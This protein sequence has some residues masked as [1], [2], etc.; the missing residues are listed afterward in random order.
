MISEGFYFNIVYLWIILALIF[1]PV[2]LRINP[3]Y[4]RYTN[5]RWGARI[6]NRMGWTLMELPSLLLFSILFLSGETVKE[7]PSWIFFGIWVIHY[8]NRIFI[9]PLR[10][11]TR[12]KKMPLAIIL[13]GTFFNLMNAFLNGYWLGSMSPVYP[14]SWLLKPAFLIGISFFV[15]GFILNQV[16]D[17][18]LISLRKGGKTG[19]FIPEKGLFKYV[20]CPNFLGEIIEWT[21][22]AIMTWSL[23]GLSF[24]IWTAANLI[25]RALHHHS[26]YKQ[27]FKDYPPK[28]KAIFP[29]IL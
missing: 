10:I 7:A 12:G 22:F 3:P 20:S 28:R 16:S 4:G 11:R 19:Y 1:F 13:S 21:G 9:F 6:N 5:K 15:F 18:Y 24:A 8:A 23:P 17:T 14:I 2:L 27:E 29:G 26:W 25:P